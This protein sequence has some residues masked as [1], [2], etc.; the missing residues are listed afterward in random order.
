MHVFTSAFK[1]APEQV[2]M[3]VHI[4]FVVL[5]V[6]FMAI[7]IIILVFLAFALVSPKII[8]IRGHV[9]RGRQRHVDEAGFYSAVLAGP[10]SDHSRRTANQNVII[11]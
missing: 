6:C 10:R 9:R 2:G 1:C 5:P 7:N 11:R 8:L 4:A 3:H